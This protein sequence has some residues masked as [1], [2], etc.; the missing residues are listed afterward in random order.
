[1]GLHISPVIENEGVGDD[2]I[3]GALAAGTWGLTH[4]IADDFPASELHLLAICREVLLHLDDEVGIRE[5]HLVA[6]R[7]A[8]H[9]RI[10]GT[11]HSVGHSRLPQRSR[12]RVMAR[13]P[14]AMLPSPPG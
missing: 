3:N 14:A 13:E 5:A 6:D 9:L 12:E 4:A 1:M 7:R 8:K 11:T 10:V 2:R